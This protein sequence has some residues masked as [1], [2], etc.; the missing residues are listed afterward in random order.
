M[1]DGGGNSYGHV[2]KESVCVVNSRGHVIW[3]HGH[4]VNSRVCGVN[5][6]V[7]G[8]KLNVYE[9]KCHGHV[10]KESVLDLDEV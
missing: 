10:V 9:E 7:Y 5:S 8:G 3:C 1:N 2:V 4:V 6:R